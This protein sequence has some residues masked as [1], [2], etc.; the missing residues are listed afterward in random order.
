MANAANWL[1]NVLSIYQVINVVSA[2]LF[3][4]VSEE[5]L[6]RYYSKNNPIE[7]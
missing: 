6:I 1:A 4:D 2:G 3:S 5:E 7:I